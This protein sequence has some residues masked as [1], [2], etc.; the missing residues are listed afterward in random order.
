MAKPSP[1][2]IGRPSLHVIQSRG[3]E[4]NIMNFYCSNYSTSFTRPSSEYNRGKNFDILAYSAGVVFKPKT[5]PENKRTGYISNVRPQIYY[6]RALDE[7]DN[8]EM[9]Y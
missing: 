6:N 9:G 4:P 7:F 2:P 8:P 1:L 5:A 3:A